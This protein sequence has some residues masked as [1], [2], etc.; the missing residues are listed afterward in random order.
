M[1]VATAGTPAAGA[2]F[3]PRGP[4]SQGAAVSHNNTVWPDTAP[5]IHFS[6]YVENAM[7]ANA[8][9]TPGPTPTQDKWFGSNALK[10]AYRLESR[11]AAA[12]ARRQSR[13]A[14]T[15]RTAVGLDEHRPTGSP[16]PAAPAIPSRRSTRGRT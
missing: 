9:F 11:R 4:E 14:G 5:V 10:Y 2:V 15:N 7:A 12:Q 8:Q 16:T 13:S 1:G 3:V 6:H